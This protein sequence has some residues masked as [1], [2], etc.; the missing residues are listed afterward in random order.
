MLGNVKPRLYEVQAY[1]LGN[2]DKRCWIV[3]HCGDDNKTYYRMCNYSA[4]E[5]L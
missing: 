1:I 2:G 3:K 5:R 4:N